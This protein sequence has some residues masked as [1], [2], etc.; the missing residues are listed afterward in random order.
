[1]TGV[2]SRGKNSEACSVEIG[3]FRSKIFWIPYQCASAADS[4]LSIGVRPKDGIARAATPGCGLLLVARLLLSTDV[5]E[6]VEPLKE[7]P[8]EGPCGTKLALWADTLP[9][10]CSP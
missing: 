4:F 3:M 7:T 10:G 5:S 9:D 6:I 8:D 1:M 2:L